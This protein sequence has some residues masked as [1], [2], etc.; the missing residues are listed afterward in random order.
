MTKGHRQN[1]AI[2]PVLHPDAK[3]ELEACV[4]RKILFITTDEQRFDALGHNQISKYKQDGREF[5][6][7]S[8]LCLFRQQRPDGFRS[9]ACMIERS[10]A[11]GNVTAFAKRK[12]TL[13]R[14]PNA[15]STPFP[16][17]G[18]PKEHK[19]WNSQRGFFQGV[20]RYMTMFGDLENRQDGNIPCYHIQLELA[21]ILVGN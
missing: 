8:K 18:H 21:G 10:E 15:K 7:G 11:H 2:R 14:D 5:G 13:R 9:Q 19:K 4:W 17:I 6:A 20:R 1:T 3:F 16:R 12:P